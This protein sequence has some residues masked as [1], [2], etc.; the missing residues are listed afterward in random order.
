MRAADFISK[1]EGA[2]QE[3]DRTAG[4][5]KKSSRKTTRAFTARKGGNHPDSSHAGQK[6]KSP[7]SRAFASLPITLTPH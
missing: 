1:L 3:L 5:G 6:R 7:K 4:S 2:L